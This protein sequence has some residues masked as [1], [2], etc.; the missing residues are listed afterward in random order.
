MAVL[1]FCSVGILG[2]GAH[3]DR[4][5]V[6][7]AVDAVA[8]FTYG[9][10]GCG[11]LIG[12]GVIDHL[13]VVANPAAETILQCDG[14]GVRIFGVGFSL[15]DGVLVVTVIGD[16]IR[17]RAEESSHGKLLAVHGVDHLVDGVLVGGVRIDGQ[18]GTGV[19]PAC[20][21]LGVIPLDLGVRGGG[22]LLQRRQGDV[23]I[24]KRVAV[25]GVVGPAEGDTGAC[26]LAV[27]DGLRTVLGIIAGEHVLRDEPWAISSCR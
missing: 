11:D 4:H 3:V 22:V 23:L 17:N 7:D 27:A 2:V 16:D 20:G 9:Q 24:A 21:V 15:V 12:V 6:L 5:Y 10:I 13:H 1:L 14:T 19:G 8:C 25:L 18:A 26:G